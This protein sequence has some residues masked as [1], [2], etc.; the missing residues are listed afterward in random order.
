MNSKKIIV[1][2]IIVLLIGLGIGFALRGPIAS[3]LNLNAEAPLSVTSNNGIIN[4]YFGLKTFRDDYTASNPAPNVVIPVMVPVWDS[5]GH[6]TKVDTYNAADLTKE[7]WNTCLQSPPDNETVG[8]CL[9]NTLKNRN[10]AIATWK[11]LTNTY[12]TL[13]YPTN[14]T[15][16]SRIADASDFTQLTPPLSILAPNQTDASPHFRLNVIDL[17][18]FAAK[19]STFVNK[20]L[21]GYI[22]FVNPGASPT[23]TTVG[24][25]AGEMTV[26][27][28]PA[29]SSLNIKTIYVLINASATSK[30][31]KLY[32]IEEHYPKVLFSKDLTNNYD[33][34]VNSI[35]FTAK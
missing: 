9:A 24:G 28:D 3:A 25:V 20:T 30:S 5:N 7:E 17:D 22:R 13:K 31:N 23:A 29:D 27:V 14:Y 15:A 35:V 18:Q 10:Q 19:N 2:I 21:A 8:A 26:S 4:A 34:I 11:N 12:Y 1:I 33:A 16:V 6:L 32:V